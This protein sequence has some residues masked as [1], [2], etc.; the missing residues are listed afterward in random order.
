MKVQM[1]EQDYVGGMN[2]MMENERCHSRQ[3]NFAY[4]NSVQAEMIQNV[5]SKKR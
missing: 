1:E 5:K 2:F 4:Q 3:K